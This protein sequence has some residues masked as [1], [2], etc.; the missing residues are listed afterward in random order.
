MSEDGTPAQRAPRR[1]RDEALAISR[2]PTVGYGKECLG[3]RMAEANSR[4]ITARRAGVPGLTFRGPPSLGI[5]RG[6]ETS[7]RQAGL[8]RVARRGEGASKGRDLRE[9]APANDEDEDEER[10]GGWP[11][12]PHPLMPWLGGRATSHQLPAT[13]GQGIQHPGSSIKHRSGGWPTPP[14]RPGRADPAARSPAAPRQQHQPGTWRGAGRRRD[15]VDA[16]R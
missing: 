3:C 14:P 16:A 8:P 11:S 10:L 13:V 6:V 5:S 9:T 15:P 12:P 7:K 4:L 1:P 2:R